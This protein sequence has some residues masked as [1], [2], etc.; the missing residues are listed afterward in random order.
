MDRKLEI[1][2]IT[3]LDGHQAA[4]YSL[5]AS[6]DP[7]VFYSGAGD[8]L[9]V[10]WDLRDL[11]TGIIQAKIPGSIFS[12]KHLAQFKMMLLGTMEGGI[13]WLDLIQKKSLKDI[14]AH[15]DGVYDFLEFGD[16]V[17]SIGGAGKL[18]NWNIA[19]Q[20]KI[21]TIH[22]SNKRLRSI[23]GNEYFICIASSDQSLYFLERSDLL[24]RKQIENSHN[25][26]VF[27][28]C[29][30]P[31]NSYILSGGRDAQL[32]VWDAITLKPMHKIPAHLST[33]NHI[34]FHPEGHLFATASRDK[35]IKIWDASTFQLLKVIDNV[36]FG[37]HNNSVNKLYWT[38]YNNWLISCG[39]DRRILV[40]QIEA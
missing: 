1:D 34:C 32:I 2:L 40:W 39:D 27:T 20:Q 7:A 26:S 28:L 37:G 5:E 21:E 8:G 31:D 3:T 22:L 14:E 16:S 19:T 10:R 18:I 36:K 15:K 17:L 13:H 23:L 24:L 6:E 33:I 12:L 9:L 11:E 25:K 29:A 38:S 4:V 35:S 30:S